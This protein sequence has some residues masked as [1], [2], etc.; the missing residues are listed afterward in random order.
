MSFLHNRTLK[1]GHTQSVLGLWFAMQAIKSLCV[2]I[3]NLMLCV[4]A[5]TQGMLK[6]AKDYNL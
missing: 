1:G 4:Y 2:M 5:W 6:L 3:K